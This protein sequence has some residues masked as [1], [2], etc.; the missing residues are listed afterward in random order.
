[1]QMPST[2]S[3]PYAYSNGNRQVAREPPLGFDAGHAAMVNDAAGEDDDDDDDGFGDF[4]IAD[5]ASH[6]TAHSPTVVA[7]QSADR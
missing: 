1:M 3:G 6:S 4:A 5:H 7:L 2:E